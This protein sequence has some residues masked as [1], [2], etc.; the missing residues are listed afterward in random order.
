[1]TNGLRKIHRIIW[2]L[3]SL[4]ILGLFL[5]IWPLQTIKESSKV[6]EIPVPKTVKKIEHE[7]LNV[8]ILTSTRIDIELI[9]PIKSAGTKVYE[10]NNGNKKAWIG[11]LREKGR[12]TFSISPKAG[13]IVV[14]DFIKEKELIVL[15]F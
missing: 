6:L 1:M 8:Y 15:K 3:L 11:D 12:Y 9:N 4:A 13:G 5:S 7:L 14:Y 2:F 10:L